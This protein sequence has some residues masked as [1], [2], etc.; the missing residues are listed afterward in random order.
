M[1]DSREVDTL[2]YT[3]IHWET[4]GTDLPSPH[5]STGRRTITSAL[6]MVETCG[7]R[8]DLYPCPSAASPTYLVSRPSYR[9]RDKVSLD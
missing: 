7:I 5:L 2:G 9:C 1:S 8:H 6:K 4:T 3:K